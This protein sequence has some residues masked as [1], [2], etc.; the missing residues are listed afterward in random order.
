MNFSGKHIA[1]LERAYLE[2]QEQIETTP[3]PPMT[4]RPD[5]VSLIHVRGVARVWE[6]YTEK[7]AAARYLMEDML[8]GL[9]GAKV[10]LVYLLLGDP[11]RISVFLGT[12]VPRY[13]GVRPQAPDGNASTLQISLQSAY[14]GISLARCTPTEIKTIHRRLNALPYAGLMMG[15]PTRKVGTEQIGVEQIERLVRGLYGTR[16]AYIIVTTPVSEQHVRAAE[17]ATLHELQ[18]LLD[19]ATSTGRRSS[20]AERYRAL[21]EAQLKRT[22]VAKTQGLWHVAAYLL[23]EDLQTFQHAKGIVKAV[24]GGE[25]SVPEPIRVLDCPQLREQICQ[26]RHIQTPPPS[27]PGRIQHDFKYINT[28]NSQELGT[29][30]H[31]PMEEIPGYVVQTYARFDVAS[32]H[33]EFSPPSASINVGDI[34]DHDRAL[35]AAY[36]FPSSHLT[37]HGLISGTT[38]SGKTN[39]V[40]YLLQQYWKQGIP[41]LVIEPAKTEYRKLLHSELGKDLQI[42]TLGDETTAP[43][44]LNPFEILPD[45]LLQTHID[46]LKS[47]FN[48]AFVM[49]APMPYVLEECL[50]RIYEDKGWDLVTGEN[51]RGTHR[52]AYPTLTD[53]Y[54]KIDVVVGNLGYE[55]RIT[56]DIKAALKTRINNLRIGGKGQMLDTRASIPLSTLL[57]KPTIL[58]L[59]Q[60]GDDDEKAFL[61][62]LVL[63]SLYEHYLSQGMQEGGELRHLTVVEEAHRLFKHV[64]VTFDTETANMKGK[65]VETFANLLSEVRA[66]GEGILVVEQIPS[67]LAADVVKNT[68]LKIM[69]RLVA[70][71]DR[72]LLGG[73]MNLTP[74]QEERIASLGTGVAA[75]YGEGDDRPILVKVPPAKVASVVRSKKEENQQVRAAMAARTN[76]VTEVEMVP[77]NVRTTRQI[78]E[79]WG[80]EIEN[81]VENKEFKEVLSRYILSIVLEENALHDEFPSV[82]QVIN[83]YRQ[84]NGNRHD[85]IARVLTCGVEEYFETKGQQYGVRYDEIET[86]RNEFLSLL[87]QVELWKKDGPLPQRELS[88]EEKNR[89]AAFQQR[90]Q[91]FCRRHYDPFPGCAQ[92][93]PN[94]QCLY[95]YHTRPLCDDSR[96]DA[97]FT[98]ALAKFTGDEIWKQVS[99]VSKV[100][101]R[102]IVGSSV[103]FEEQRKIALCFAIQKSEFYPAYIDSENRKKLLD[104]LMAQPVEHWEKS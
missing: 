1:Y 31:L 7:I 79:R 39:T 35:G 90:Y 18:L 5:A 32:A 78:P 23:S 56:M 38:G 36:H 91:Q 80:R 27:A 104:G 71:E 42:F 94:M 33:D 57:A 99:N 83:K 49:Y 6:Q 8:A 88:I 63:V 97:N 13:D 10:P 28:L 19:D 86:V 101:I 66:Y 103:I 29:L 84:H 89:I 82:L 24:F 68:S 14:A 96:L 12:F 44:R 41:F 43:F 85:I 69:H 74:E 37:R 11:A 72:R 22:E 45:V 81:I 48:A 53:L 15:T 52:N 47:V 61:I 93:C 46:L 102:R 95:R 67:K 87:D 30:T 9:Y 59:E 50:H 3:H 34:R 73:T 62:G 92:V 16:W 60:V 2:G 77:T 25:H 54:R 17:Q 100:A 20:M 76:E 26:F 55:D 21:L 70:A 40:F 4:P 75:V 58:E 51:Q 98:N 64:P 65:A